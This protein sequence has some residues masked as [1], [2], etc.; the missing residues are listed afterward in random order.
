MCVKWIILSELVFD[1]T[2]DYQLTEMNQFDIVTGQTN[3]MKF[4]PR[5]FA[6]SSRLDKFLFMNL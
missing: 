1:S 4:S 3:L 2:S 5:V 6:P